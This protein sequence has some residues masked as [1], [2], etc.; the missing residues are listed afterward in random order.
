MTGCGTGAAVRGGGVTGAAGGFRGIVTAGR[1]VVIGAGAV[2]TSGGFAIAGPG[3]RSFAGGGTKG[4]LSFFITNVSPESESESAVEPAWIS[5]AG[6]EGKAFT[7]GS[8]WISGVGFGGKASATKSVWL[9]AAGFGSKAFA[10][11]SVWLLGAGFGGKGLTKAGPGCSPGAGL[12]GA[13]T[14]P[15]FKRSVFVSPTKLLSAW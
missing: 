6:L 7:T 12:A 13:G 15:A 3:T 9:L 5:G 1:A 4:T 8:V 14:F 10:K 11:E 2:S